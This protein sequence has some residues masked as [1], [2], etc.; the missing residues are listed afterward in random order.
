MTWLLVMAW[1][2]SVF[3]D[4]NCAVVN[5]AKSLSVNGPNWS[6]VKACS[7]VVVKPYFSCAVVSADTWSVVKAW[8][9]SVVKPAI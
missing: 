8:T 2:L 3:N 7:M 1:T 9:W 4:A 5:T 6:V